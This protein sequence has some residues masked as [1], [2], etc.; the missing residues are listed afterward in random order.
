M[1]E[2]KMVPFS[3]RFEPVGTPEDSGEAFFER[4][5]KRRSVRDFS[6]RPVSRDAITWLVRAAGSAPSG[7]NR[8]P[9][10]FVCVSDPGLKKEIREGAEEEER[11]FYRERGG[12]AWL[13]DLA[14]FGTGP[15]KGFLETAPWLVAVFRLIRNDDG[16]AVY[17]SGESVGIAVGL[18]LAAAQ[19]AGLATL[20]HTPSPM[21]FLGRILRRPDVERPFVLIPVGYPAEDCRVPVAALTRKP[22]DEVMVVCE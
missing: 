12:Q 15:D 1:S 8:Q 14:P 18:F 4:M 10:R 6:D 22:L 2:V 16:S 17:Y 11:A 7:A 19:H 13:D 3:D 21:A 5:R 20:V 9:W